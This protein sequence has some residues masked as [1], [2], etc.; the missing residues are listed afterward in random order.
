[1]EHPTEVPSKIR[2]VL[3]LEADDVLTDM[4]VEL[5]RR[6][7]IAVTAVRTLDEALARLSGGQ[8]GVDLLIFDADTVSSTIPTDTLTKWHAWLSR[9]RRPLPC[10]VVSVQPASARR[11]R[12]L[13]SVPGLPSRPSGPMWLQK[14]F[15][16]DEFL[17]AVRDLPA[18][19][20][21]ISDAVGTVRL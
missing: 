10:M 21:A 20:Q 12:F 13:L 2:Q 15:R 3:I 1:M 14:P 9:C 11:L 4:M 5:L 19:S 6:H 7:G 8:T 16:N 18:G 17:S